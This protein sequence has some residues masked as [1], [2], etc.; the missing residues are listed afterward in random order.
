MEDII[1]YTTEYPWQRIEDEPWLWFGRFTKY[2]LPQGPGRSLYHAYEL[3]VAAEHPEVAEARRKAH[4]EKMTSIAVWSRMA[5]D[6]HWRDRSKA[7][8]RFTYQ[9]AQAHVDLARITL[10]SSANKAAG[11]LVDALTNERL[12]VA[13]AKEILDRAG[14]P[15]TVNVGIGPADKFTADELRAAEDEISDWENNQQ[16]PRLE[17]NG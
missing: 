5:K 13:A 10:L 11:A 9:S 16:R 1:P 6:W 3:M 15:G 8:D 17:S 7:F 2:F 12:K 14:L 4:K